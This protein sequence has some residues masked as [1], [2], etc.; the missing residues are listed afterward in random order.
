MQET[1][2]K[3]NNL[4]Y[5]AV[6]NPIVNI[7]SAPIVLILHLYTFY[8][9]SPY[10]CTFSFL[11]DSFL[12]NR[13]WQSLPKYP[14]NLKLTIPP[15]TIGLTWRKAST[16]SPGER[17]CYGSN[18]FSQSPD[19]AFQRATSG[20]VSDEMKLM[21][22]ALVPTTATTARTRGVQLP[23]C[24]DRR[25]ISITMSSPNKYH[26]AKLQDLMD[27]VGGNNVI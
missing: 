8:F 23:H 5:F 19:R 15:I 10:L 25:P 21:L 9:P 4:A 3:A 6:P 20:A 13:I 1:I 2:C 24:S 22:Q 17:S 26:G 14:S 7:K 12:P 18:A 16:T 11:L 27:V